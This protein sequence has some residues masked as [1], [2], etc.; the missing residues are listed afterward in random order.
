MSNRESSNGGNKVGKRNLPSSMSSKDRGNKPHGKKN[1][2]AGNGESASNEGSLDFSKLLD[3]VIFALSGFIN[4]ER[5]ILRSQA[6]E[7]GGEYRPDWTSD[8]TLLVCAFPNTP[9][10]R[11][12]EANGGTIVSKV[13]I[14]LPC[15]CSNTLNV[16]TVHEWISECY[17]HRKLVEIER[18]LMHAGKPWRRQNKLHLKKGHN[19]RKPNSKKGKTP[20]KKRVVLLNQ[21]LLLDPT[22][23]SCLSEP[24]SWTNSF[25]PAPPVLGVIL[26]W[27]SHVESACLTSCYTVAFPEYVLTFMSCWILP[28]GHLSN[29][30]APNSIKVCLSPSKLKE[31]AVDDLSKTISWLDSQEEKPDSSDL[32]KIAAQ[33]VMTCLEDAIVALKENRD[34]HSV[35]EQW[36]FVPHVVE[37]LS[38]LAKAGSGSGSP[39]KDELYK[40]AIACKQVYQMEYDNVDADPAKSK[41]RKTSNAGDDKK[42]NASDDE[43][44]ESDETIV[45]TEEEIEVACRDL[46]SKF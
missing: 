45:M 18:H 32:K 28:I 29:G 27:P 7:M 8:C 4:P 20:I 30:G 10:F 34:V 21:D 16:L 38:K 42:K 1:E 46:A 2:D 22:H 15:R 14:A 35:M 12:V 40:H 6:L 31:W 37:E 5:G 26:S 44:F 24:S 39:S 3:G 11:Q 17:S 43:G 23:S 25:L 19:I 41:K 13:V 9:K 36:R 33:G